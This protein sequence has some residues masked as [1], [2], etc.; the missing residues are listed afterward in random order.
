MSQIPSSI[1]EMFSSIFSSGLAYNNRYEVLINYPNIFRTLNSDA[2]RQ[3]AVRCDSISIP[4]RSF[5]TVPYRFYGPARNMPYEPIY[6]GELTMSVILSE[7]LQER[8]F[9]EQWM[10]GVCSPNDYKFNYYD[11]YTAP[12]TINILNRASQITYQIAVEEAYPKAMGD[13]QIGYDKDNEFMRQDVTIAFRKYL[14]VRLPP[15]PQVNQT[16]PQLLQAPALSPER[17]LTRNT[18]ARNGQFYNVSSDGTVN[19]LYAPDLA[20][21]LK[22]NLPLPR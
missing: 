12:L 16:V 4:G 22:N 2:A 3:I 5:S 15:V 13:I 21:A 20:N 19:G 17:A 11:Q 8:E 18:Y 7:S 14:P 10:N 1:T 9:F 6:S